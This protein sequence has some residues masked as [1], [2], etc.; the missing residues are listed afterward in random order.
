VGDDRQ[1]LLRR[2]RLVDAA[3]KV[4]GVGSVGTRCLVGLFEGINS[5][6]WLVLQVKE[7]T[8]SVLEPHI[9]TS[10]HANHGERVVTGQRLTQA[11]SDMFLGWGEGGPDGRH[12]Y[13]RQLWDGKAS[14][15]PLTLTPRALRVYASLCAWALARAHAKTGDRTAIS[16][17]IGGGDRFAKGIADFSETYAVQAQQDQAALVA[18]VRGGRIEA[19]TGV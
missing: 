2:Y 10:P 12:Y 6:D 7:A 4:V 13:W 3:R 1:H 8:T 11:A 14:I 18:A 15:D 19:I 17:Y 9:G 5:T 16:A